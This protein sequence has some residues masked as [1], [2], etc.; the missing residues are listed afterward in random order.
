MCLTLENGGE[1][2]KSDRWLSI[3]LKTE[4]S[5]GC[6]YFRRKR[7]RVVNTRAI[8]LN[9]G[10]CRGD[11]DLM[12]TWRTCWRNFD[13]G[14][15]SYYF[16]W[17]RWNIITN[18]FFNLGKWLTANN[19]NKWMEW[20]GMDGWNGMERKTSLRLAIR[21]I[22]TGYA[23]LVAQRW[24]NAGIQRAD[25]APALN[26]DGEWQRTSATIVAKNVR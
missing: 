5:G 6:R 21:D 4:S 18:L 20:N 24:S 8:L 25:P 14:E 2:R 19:G 12:K 22:N 10:L 3:V 16:L 17:K 26:D 11:P 1:Y 7:Q 13:G 9:G 23:L 15:E